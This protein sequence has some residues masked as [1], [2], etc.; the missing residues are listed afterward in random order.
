MNICLNK[1]YLVLLTLALFSSCK[2]SHDCDD[3]RTG[4]FVYY[5]N[6]LKSDVLITRTDSLQTEEVVSTGKK[7]V[8]EIKWDGDCQCTLHYLRVNFPISDSDLLFLRDQSINTKIIQNERD[9]YITESLT[10]GMTDFYIDTI[11]KLKQ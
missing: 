5:S 8:S 7:L 2:N 10:S 6:Y 9:F 1:C 11:K 4:K 3:I